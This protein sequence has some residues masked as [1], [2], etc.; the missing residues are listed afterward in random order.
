LN[1]EK[2]TRKC[3]LLSTL[4]VLQER[5]DTAQRYTMKFIRHTTDSTDKPTD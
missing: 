3:R 1:A 2:A 5:R 4:Y